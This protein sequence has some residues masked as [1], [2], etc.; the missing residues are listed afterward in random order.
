ME[1]KLIVTGFMATGKTAVGAALARHFGWPFVDTDNRLVARAGKPI[2]SIFG[3]DGE[4]RFREMEREIIRDI[5]AETGAA[6][7][8]TGGGALVDEENYQALSRCGV[9]VCLSARPEVILRRIGP[10]AHLRPK[11]MEGDKP[12]AHRVAELLAE[13]EP[14]YRRA[15]FTVDTSDLTINAVVETVLAEF[16]KRGGPQWRSSE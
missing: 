10:R 14:A 13:R 9:I 12:L 8:S 7:V 2:A 6:V 3:E 4:V 16:A 15:S 11:L 1:R 5:A